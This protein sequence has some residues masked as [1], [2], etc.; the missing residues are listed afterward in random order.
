MCQ[1]NKKSKTCKMCSFTTDDSSVIKRFH[2]RVCRICYNKDMLIRNTNKMEH[3]KEF[4]RA[5]QREYQR[6]VYRNKMANRGR[7]VKIRTFEEVPIE[8]IK[9]VDYVK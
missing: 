8:T 1:E 3:Y 5:Y 9:V 2:G 6:N 4:N 7:E